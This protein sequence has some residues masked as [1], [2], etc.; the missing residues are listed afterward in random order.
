MGT[1]RNTCHRR[2]AAAREKD[3]DVGIIW[4]GLLI[5]QINSINFKVYINAMWLNYLVSHG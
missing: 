4:A 2:A 5:S 1:E 3:E